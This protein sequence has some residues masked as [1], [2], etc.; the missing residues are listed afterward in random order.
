MLRRD[1]LAS[2]SAAALSAAIASKADAA[3]PGA[4]GEW[5]NRQPGVAYRRL[6][7]TGFMISEVVMGGNTISPNNYEH[8]LLA[9][10]KGLNYLDTAPA[11]GN[12]ES[13]L[14]FARVLKAR[15]RDSFFLNTKVSAF[16]INRAK[17][18]RSIFDSLSEV[19]QKKLQASAR[20]Q[21]ERRRALDPDY[22]CNYFAS[23][24]KEMLD[25]A[26]AN[27]I[28]AKYGRQIDRDK[29]YRRLI[30]TSLDE[31]LKRLGTDHVDLLMCPHGAC[32]PYEVENHPEIFEAFET[33]KRQGKVRFLGVSAH[34]DPGG[35]L[36]GAVKTGVYSVAMIAYNIVNRAYTNPAVARAHRAGL[37]VIAM[38]AARPVHHGRNNGQPNDPRRVTMIEDAVPGPLKV[39]QKAY[40]WVLRNP[41]ITAAI[42]EMIDANLVNDNLRLAAPKTPRA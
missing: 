10:D 3:P 15:R 12:L 35:V 17:I 9:L 13:E 26:L 5:R 38:K 33:L 34:N 4:E 37:G 25:A 24:E 22:F 1:F 36:D 11:Y 6:G 7:H 32:T 19:E 2:A 23:Q 31:S 28:A 16:D 39:P 30:L 42:S 21:L 18:H 20:D 29:N 8:V 14:G 40:L 27:V 41:G